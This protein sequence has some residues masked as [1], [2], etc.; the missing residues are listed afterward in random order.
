MYLS[1][2]IRA[3]R[4]ENKKERKNYRLGNVMCNETRLFVDACALAKRRKRKTL[5]ITKG[6]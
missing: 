3:E 4:S 5:E 6:E 1:R 2:T